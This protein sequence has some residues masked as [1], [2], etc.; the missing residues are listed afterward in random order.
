MSSAL[1][2]QRRGSQTKKVASS[3]SMC[4]FSRV[5]LLIFCA[6]RALLHFDELSTLGPTLPNWNIWMVFQ[7]LLFMHLLLFFCIVYFFTV[8]YY[9]FPL[10][11]FFWFLVLPVW[12][13][14]L[15]CLSAKKKKAFF[16]NSALIWV[17]GSWEFS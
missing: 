14:A 12:N 16:T 1:C 13:T 4:F 15:V 9:Y 8:F 6:L 5:S 11:C 3:L 17:W 2:L 7:I 10:L